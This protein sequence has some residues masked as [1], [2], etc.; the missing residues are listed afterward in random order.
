MDLLWVWAVLLLVVALGL[1]ILAIFFPTGGI[2]EFLSF[3]AVVAAII[4]AFRQSA[5]TGFI[6]LCAAL[7]AVPIVVVAALNLLPH[8]PMGRQMLLKTPTSDDVLPDLPR[9]RQLESMVGHVGRAKCK[10][11]PS[12]AVIVD[13]RTI[14]AVSEGVPID[15]G[16]RV[17][18]IEVR[19]NR[20]V[21][22]P[23]EEEP[24]SA[25]EKDPLARPVDT[26]VSDP[27]ADPPA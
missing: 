4:M 13:G 22:R 25:N 11:L 14:D 12:G 2:L 10:M 27:F 18:V 15:A 19:G 7:V 26:I 8:T 9:Q 3:A 6:I 20:V 1:A 5:T 21:V 17:R 24:P 23:L 16:Q